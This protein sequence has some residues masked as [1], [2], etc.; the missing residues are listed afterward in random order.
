[1]SIGGFQVS[2]LKLIISKL[3]RNKKVAL[4]IN[5]VVIGFYSYILSFR[6]GIL[7]VFLCLVLTSIFRKVIRSKYDILSLSAIVTIFIAPT[8]VFD[9][10]FCLSYLCTF[11]V[12]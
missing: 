2:F 6:S 9:F 4:I 8:S 3:I 12:M 5:L 10:G 1:M 11:C 7:R